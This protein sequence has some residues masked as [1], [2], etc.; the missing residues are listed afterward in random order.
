MRYEQ[1]VFPSPAQRGNIG[2]IAEVCSVSCPQGE[3]QGCGEYKVPRQGRKGALLRA[4][5]NL[6]VPSSGRM[7]IVGCCR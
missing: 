2:R 5:T 7:E 6:V 1:R 3:P 4:M